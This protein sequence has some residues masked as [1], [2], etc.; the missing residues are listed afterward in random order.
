MLVKP[1]RWRGFIAMFS[2]RTRLFWF[3]A[4]ASL[5]KAA[6]NVSPTTAPAAELKISVQAAPG[7]TAARAFTNFP[8]GSA[9]V[10]FRGRTADGARDI[11]VADWRDGRWSEPRM[12]APDGWITDH[13]PAAPPAL[14]SR[15]GQAA[16]AWFTAAGNDPRIELA[17]SPDAGG[18]WLIPQRVSEGKPD[19]AVSVVLLRDGSQVVAWKENEKLL[20]RR[21][22]PQGDLG[23]VAPA[24]ESRAPLDSLQL[25]VL[26]DRDDDAPVRLLLAYSVG[27]DAHT[28]AVTLPSLKELAA[29]DSVCS[30]GRASK[31]AQRGLELHGTVTAV[32]AAAGTV[33]AKH[34]AIP[35]AMPAMTMAFKADDATLKGIKPGQEFL[36][37][38]EARN[39][40]WWLL[41]VRV[42]GEAL[43]EKK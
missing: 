8:D 29:G 14:D 19:A 42:L 33:T 43:P 13:P 20:L 12:L 22:S 10:A 16:A 30:C 18:V 24:A 7:G 23:P 32:D 26:A 37:R 31:Q 4:L 17:T 3:L 40:E 25:T 1:L 38:I 5:A 41:D 28:A 34:D 6:E 15:D 21:V 27:E 36:G 11:Q 35:G 9:L 39:A 2:P